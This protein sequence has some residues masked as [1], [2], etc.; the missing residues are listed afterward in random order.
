MKWKERGIEVMNKIIDR[1][2]L[3]YLFK[4]KK[5]ILILLFM[6]S[7]VC[8]PFI[9]A[10]LHSSGSD[11]FSIMYVIVMS[12]IIGILF[13]IGLPIYLFEMLYHK[14][15]C[16]LYFSLPIKREKLFCTISLY[17]LIVVISCVLVNYF[18]YIGLFSNSIHPGLSWVVRYVYSPS[19]ILFSIICMQMLVTFICIRS[20]NILDTLFILGGH[21]LAPFIIYAAVNTFLWTQ[22]ERFVLGT[23]NYISMLVDSLFVDFLEYT[24]LPFVS[25]SII[26]DILSNHYVY[27]GTSYI[28]WIILSIGAWYLSYRYFTKRKAEASGKRTDFVLGYPYIIVVVTLGLIFLALSLSGTTVV[29]CLTVIFMLYL[30]MI[31]FSKRRIALNFKMIGLFAVLLVISYS[32]GYACVQT[33]GFHM[34]KEVPDMQ[35]LESVRVQI[36][37]YDEPLYGKDVYAIEIKGDDLD[38]LFKDTANVHEKLL[39]YTSNSYENLQIAFIY[40]Y[41]NGTYSERRY[42]VDESLLKSFVGDYFKKYADHKYQKKGVS[43][44]YK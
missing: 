1:N 32:I 26:K 25:F 43:V 34:I 27:H 2:Y 44:N 21:L 13:S 28:F 15:S 12:N 36:N 5:S 3:N 4:S 16:D 23:G 24:S 31:F 11:D 40:Y 29:V 14:T 35:N 19:I 30:F 39:S 22:I 41:E 9:G 37:K 6:I 17:N 7:F 8:I 38:E 42:Y 10:L 20:N 18:L 33:R